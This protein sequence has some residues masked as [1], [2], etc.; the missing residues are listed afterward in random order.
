M[1]FVVATNDAITVYLCLTFFENT[2]SKDNVKKNL[3]AKQHWKAYT[4]PKPKY[5]MR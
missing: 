3:K 2:H 1:N 4:G 5:S